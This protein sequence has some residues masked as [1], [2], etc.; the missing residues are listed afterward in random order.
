MAVYLFGSVARGTPHAGSD[1]D[2]GVLMAQPPPRTLEGLELEGEL[3]KLLGHPVQLVVLNRA[4]VDLIHRVLR[5]G[6]L[7]LDA[8]PGKLA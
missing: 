5:D 8:D 2:V 1:V 7:L 6:K 4:P 3:E